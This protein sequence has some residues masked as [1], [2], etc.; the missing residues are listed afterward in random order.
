M[1]LLGK[2]TV[3]LLQNMLRR[4]SIKGFVSLLSGLTI[5]ISPGERGH[6]LREFSRTFNSWTI[7]FMMIQGSLQPQQVRH[8]L[9][10]LLS[11]SIEGLVKEYSMS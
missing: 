10:K 1:T 6:Q 5:S 4:I 2:D 11:V 3:A 7:A 8:S 9:K